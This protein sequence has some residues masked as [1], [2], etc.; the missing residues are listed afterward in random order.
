MAPYIAHLCNCRCFWFE[1]SRCLGYKGQVRTSPGFRDAPFDIWGEGLLFLLLAN[2][3]FTSGGKQAFFSGDQRPTIFFYVSAKKFL[4]YAFPIMYVTIWCFFWSTYCSSI[5]TTNF[6]SAHIFNKL[7]FL[8]F[9]ATNY[10]FSSPPPPRYQMVRPLGV[11]RKPP[12]LHF[13]KVS[14][15]LYNYNFCIILEFGKLIPG[16]HGQCCSNVGPP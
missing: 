6:F 12:R 4:S 14:V 1:L 7:F 11:S 15:Y 8:I 16:K 10:F 2:F 5:S 3:F 13:Q 9:V